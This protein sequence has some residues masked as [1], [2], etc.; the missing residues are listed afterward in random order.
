[1]SQQLTDWQ[2]RVVEE[3]EELTVKLNAL[4]AFISSDKFR[5]LSNAER[6]RLDKQRRRCMTEYLKVLVERIE[7]FNLTDQQACEEAARKG[8][9]S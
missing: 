4:C 3:M 5:E 2:Q 7:C 9:N 6:F 8:F 1:M